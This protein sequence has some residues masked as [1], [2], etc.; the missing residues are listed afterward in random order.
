LGRLSGRVSAASQLTASEQRVADLVA[1][2][3]TNKE[4]AAELVITPRTVE[5]HLTRIY[6][7]L[8]IRSRVELV[9]LR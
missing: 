2:G 8:G 5:A 9:R 6:A 1:Q 3:L 4:I 7:K